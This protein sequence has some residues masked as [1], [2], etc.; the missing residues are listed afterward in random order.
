MTEKFKYVKI[1]SFVAIVMAII[2]LL[3]SVI[4]PR[5]NVGINKWEKAKIW[6]QNEPENT[7]DAVFV[8]DSEV[9]SA[10]SPLE[11]WNTYGYATYNLSSGAIKS[12]ESYE[13][14][15]TILK[16]QNPKIVFIEC[17][18]LF[19]SYDEMDD[20]YR[21][22]GEKI[23]LF[24]YHDVWK[25]YIDP[26]HEFEKTHNYT[27]KGYVYYNSLKPVKNNN[28]MAETTKV[29]DIDSGTLKYFDA[30]IKLCE[31]KGAEVVLFSSPSRKNWNYSKH[32]GVVKLAKEYGYEYLDL[33]LIDEVGID[34]TK[35]T[36]D[37]GDHVNHTG[38]V[39]VTEYL[40][41]YLA[42][43]DILDDHRND[44]AYSEWDALY[45]KYA[46]KVESGAKE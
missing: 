45:E 2:L 13:L 6:A 11:L 30:M 27:Y 37:K 35:H 36:R 43:K 33:N 7:I 18:F 40:G 26:D 3:S 1:I 8:G 34:W 9:Y 41:K 5:G 31:D 24:K 32:N 38:A 19:R 44:P 23:P 46:E 29:T 28:Y 20:I 17:N 14:L 10:I 25:S 12:Y 21:Q 15:N 4:T 16:T 39:K 42:K 22:I